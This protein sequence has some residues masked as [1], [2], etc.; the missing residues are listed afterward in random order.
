MNKKKITIVFL[1]LLILFI[2]YY[3]FFLVFPI[4]L[5]GPPMSIY[6]I[7]NMD[8]I[9]HNV[10]IEIFDS[11]NNSSYLKT[12]TIHPDETVEF[13]RQINWFIPITSEYITWSHGTY[14]FQFT[15][16][17]NISKNITT[18][19]RTWQTISVWLYYQGPHDI[20]AIPIE[21]KIATV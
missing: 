8:S 11:N 17:N 21:I 9:T 2:G 12:Y 19:V 18:L 13:E 15:V 14:T 3:L 4:I 5:V 1:I 16:D 20:E 6:D 10:S 7:R